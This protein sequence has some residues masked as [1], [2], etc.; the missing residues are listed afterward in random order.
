MIMAL[1]GL[2][3]QGPDRVQLLVD[4]FNRQDIVGMM[5]QVHPDIVWCHVDGAVLAVEAQGRE[6]LEASMIAYFEGYGQVRS[7]LSQV[8]DYGSYVTAL[9]KVSWVREGAKRT[10]SALSVY[11]FKDGL[12]QSVWYFPAEKQ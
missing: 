6:Q 9:E 7:E 2:M 4:A 5:A 10:Q 1:F 12:I 8:C 11:H 3:V